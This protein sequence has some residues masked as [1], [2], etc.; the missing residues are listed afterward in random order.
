MLLL[1]CQRGRWKGVM[2]QDPMEAIGGCLDEGAQP[3]VHSGKRR[4]HP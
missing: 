1:P 4:K 2:D 3:Y